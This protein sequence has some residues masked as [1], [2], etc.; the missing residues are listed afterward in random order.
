MGD[1]SCLRLSLS[2]I[3]FG[4]KKS[5]TLVSAE[6]KICQGAFYY[7][8]WLLSLNRLKRHQCL[9]TINKCFDEHCWGHCGDR[10][11]E[12]VL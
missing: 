1:H 6:I 4:A 9:L 2:A 11:L 7:Y 8:G 10:D 3:E 5:L 12:C